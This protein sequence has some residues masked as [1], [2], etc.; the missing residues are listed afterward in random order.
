MTRPT[1]APDIFTS[2]FKM[3]AELQDALASLAR[4]AGGPGRTRTY[5]QTVMSGRL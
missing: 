4:I 5:N 2:S 3:I 1:S